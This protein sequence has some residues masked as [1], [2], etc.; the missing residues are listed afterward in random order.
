M[1]ELYRS[2]NI[3][4]RQVGAP[5]SDRWVITFD[6]H[7]IGNGF[8]RPGFGEQFLQANNIPAI[9]VLGRGN[10]WYQYD[11]IFAAIDAI[12]TATIGATRKITY[13]SS[14][15]GYAALRCADAIG[16]HGVLALSPQWSINPSYVKW[17]NR[18]SQDAHRIRWNSALDGVLRCP[19]RPVL[20]Y[21]PTLLFD[22]RHADLI[23]AST[24]SS[25]ITVPYGGHP[26]STFLGEIGLLPALLQSVLQDCLDEAAL[27]AEIKKRRSGSSVY[28]GA[29]A[30]RQPTVRPHTAIALARRACA[31][32]PDGTLAMLSLAR[33][34]SRSG[35][36]SESIA[37][38][39]KI[40]AATE[41]LSIYLVP[42][43]EALMAAGE[44]REALTVA[45]EVV[46]TLPDVSH[47]RNWYATMLWKRGARSD[48]VE[49]LRH[50]IALDP[51]NRRY[52]R[53]LIKYRATWRIL[54]LLDAVHVRGVH[55]P[56]IKS[57]LHH[58]RCE[59]NARH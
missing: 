49:E 25:L 47:L 33:I 45:R 10:D 9:H 51:H 17:E 29:L 36:H 28:L 34:L 59:A 16:A 27:M 12:R 56:A 43:A 24:P 5:S 32:R 14:M 40:V 13:G 15:G 57:D 35:E 3:V 18:W 58:A 52:R 20:V 42:F 44:Y 54:Y 37:L 31:A 4:V 11:D 7:S 41:R 1:V 8:N 48:A 21:D 50:A 19:V 38:H 39:R 53:K 46:D 6:H 30:E 2:N 55:K 23:A 26:A 22:R